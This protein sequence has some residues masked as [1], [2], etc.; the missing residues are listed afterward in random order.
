[1]TPPWTPLN[2]KE[3]AATHRR[4][5]YTYVVY[6]PAYLPTSSATPFTSAA[7][8]DLRQSQIECAV[9]RRFEGTDARA[10]KRYATL[11]PAPPPGLRSS[12]Q[13]RGAK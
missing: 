8:G 5:K 7:A 2:G 6:F 12:R 4:I 1:M 3:K 9:W 11:S 13:C 10:G